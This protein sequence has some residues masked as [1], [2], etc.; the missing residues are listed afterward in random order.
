MLVQNHV[1]TQ[2]SS[3]Y[4]NSLSYTDTQVTASYA[5]AVSYTDMQVAA[6]YTNAV[7]YTD[8]EVAS[9]YANAV[10][11]TDTQA[12]STYANAVAYTD[13]KVAAA[14]PSGAINAFNLS[15]CPSGWLAADGGGGR[16]DLRG[17]FLRGLNNFGTGTRS[18]GRQ[19]PDGGSR[20]VGSYQADQMQSHKHTDSGHRH[21]YQGRYKHQT[22]DSGGGGGYF[23]HDSTKNTSTSKANLGNPTNSGT[24]AGNPRHGK[25]TRS[26][27]VAVIYCVKN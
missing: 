22:A 24:G 2:V 18:D 21:S 23:A 6:S 4:S 10:A 11:Y 27:N 14:V 26:K 16:P 15:S 25:E 13:A 8:T 17:M 3:S 19:D 1:D 9:T 12:A 7:A 5:S 20:S